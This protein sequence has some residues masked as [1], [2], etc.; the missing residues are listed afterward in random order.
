MSIDQLQAVQA[1]ILCKIVEQS[2]EKIKSS[3][4]DEATS[5]W[6]ISI[7]GELRSWKG[8]TLKAIKEKNLAK[9]CSVNAYFHNCQDDCSGLILK[10][11]KGLNT[12]DWPIL[13][14]TQNKTAVHLTMLVD[15]FSITKPKGD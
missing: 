2:E 3:C 13:K 15:S 4:A 11:V 7:V 5:E 1:E 6:L 10:L 8:D 9:S 12:T 14:M